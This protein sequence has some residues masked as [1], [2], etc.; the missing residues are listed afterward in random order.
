MEVSPLS[1]KGVTRDRFASKTR[2]NDLRG[3]SLLAADGEKNRALGNDVR[4]V[5][6]VMNRKR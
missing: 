1:P 2:S 6:E 3:D 5:E 4:A